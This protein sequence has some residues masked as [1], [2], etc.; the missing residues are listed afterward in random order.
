MRAI[1]ITWPV[2]TLPT[3]ARVSN[4]SMEVLTAPTATVRVSNLSIEVLSAKTATVRVSNLSL[5]VLVPLIQPTLIAIFPTAPRRPPQ[6]MMKAKA[7]SSNRGRSF[8]VP[9]ATTMTRQAM[10]FVMT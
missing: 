2:V 3:N 4:L 6:W 8:S 7:L 1:R 5:E 10:L 9:P